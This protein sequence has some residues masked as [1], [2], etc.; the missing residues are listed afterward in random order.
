MFPII[1]GCHQ[2]EI[3]CLKEYPRWQLRNLFDCWRSDLVAA[4]KLGIHRID[5]IIR[6]I[7]VLYFIKTT[8]HMDDLWKLTSYAMII[9]AA[10]SKR[11]RIMRIVKCLLV[12]SQKRLTIIKF[13]SHLLVPDPFVSNQIDTGR[14]TESAKKIRAIRKGASVRVQSNITYVF[15]VVSRSAFFVGLRRCSKVQTLPVGEHWLLKNYT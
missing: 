14:S 3:K 2:K 11:A 10:G 12:F 9:S 7:E 15:P 6:G 1:P 4:P 13:L 8:H 5:L